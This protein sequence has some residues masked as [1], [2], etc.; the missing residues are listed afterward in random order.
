M[1]DLLYRR[2]R[3]K[4]S[5]R[6][7]VGFCGQQAGQELRSVASHN[8]VTLTFEIIIYIEYRST[9]LTSFSLSMSPAAM[10][11][12]GIGAGGG[13]QKVLLQSRSQ[14]SVVENDGTFFRHMRKMALC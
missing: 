5:E 2:Y 10:E 13:L 8:N 14:S 9:S 3:R 1:A 12:L 6:S 4:I 7:S 11:G